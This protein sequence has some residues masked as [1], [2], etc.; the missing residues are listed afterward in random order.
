MTA[1]GVSIQRVRGGTGVDRGTPHRMLVI[2][3]S[4]AIPGSAG[5]IN[6][7]AAGYT[8]VATLVSDLGIGDGVSLAAH[9]LT[10]SD[11]NPSPPSLWFA[12][13]KGLANTVAGVRGSISVTGVTGT[14]VVSNFGSTPEGTYQ[15]RVR[16]ITGGTIGVTG[17]VLQGSLDDGRTWLPTSSLGTATTWALNIPNP[18]GSA[19]VTGIQYDFAAGTLV[20]DD[21]W[22]EGITTPPDWAVGDLYTAGS[23][24]TGLLMT[25]AQS[26][27]GFGLI[28]ITEPLVAADVAT[29]KAGLTAMAGV[30]PQ[31]R[32][33]LVVRFRLQGV[34]ESDS[35]YLAALATFRAACGD[36]ERIHVVTGTGWLTEQY[37]LFRLRHSPLGALMHRLQGQ[38]AIAGTKGEKIAQS[39]GWAARGPLF[40]FTIRDDNGAPIAH[41]ERLRPGA[42]NTYSGAGGFGAVYYEAAPDR[43]GTYY[44]STAWTLCANATSNQGVKTLMDNRTASAIESAIYAAMVGELGGADVVEDGVLDEGAALAL[45]QNARAA[46]APFAK[47]FANFEDP[48]LIVVDTA[49]TITGPDSYV[50]VYINDKLFAYR[51]GITVKLAHERTG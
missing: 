39:P 11:D 8:N 42:T 51:K 49:V 29:L 33:T 7:G 38:S 43:R 40:G 1:P 5:A 36:D 22:T 6:G 45:A 32:P 30:N 35:T 24:A 37:H 44:D 34:S 31:C 21:V 12:S 26:S 27:I 41:D 28:V 15:P 9:A 13:T 50:T 16:V 20:A 3:T 19:Y 2:G 46:L 17:I 48:N 47:E 14:S 4:S 25:A 10:P 23:P 18:N